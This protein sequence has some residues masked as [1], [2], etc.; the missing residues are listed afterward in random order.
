VLFGTTVPLAA[1]A[2][3]AVSFVVAP[4]GATLG[5][6]AATP[7]V[8]PALVGV[9]CAPTAATAVDAIVLDVATVPG[10][11]TVVAPVRCCAPALA[12]NAAP[13][14]M[15]MPATRHRGM[16]RHSIALLDIATSALMPFWTP[17]RARGRVGRAA[18]GMLARSM[19]CSASAPHDGCRRGV[20][21]RAR[22]ARALERAQREGRVHFFVRQLA[23]RARRALR[24]PGP[25]AARH[26]RRSF[27]RA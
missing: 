3:T 21:N 10:G 20:V 9:L 19:P 16:C 4:T 5:T 17:P 11:Q 15:V 2:A 22:N 25:V 6:G 8:L 23:T 7:A 26:D 12:A 13:R 27:G 14:T 24:H 18:I 1:T